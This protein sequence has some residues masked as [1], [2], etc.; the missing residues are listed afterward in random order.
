M[1][2][3]QLVRIKAARAGEV[4]AAFGVD[5][6][7]LRRWSR[8]ADGQGVAALVPA[9]R[10][11]QGPTKLTGQ[12]VANIQ[13]RRAQRASLRAIAAAEGVSTASVRCVLAMDTDSVTETDSGTEAGMGEMGEQPKDEALEVAEAEPEVL[14]QPAPHGT[15]RALAP[16]GLLDEATPVSTPAARV[17]LAGMLAALPALEATGLL[18][19]APGCL[20]SVAGR[21]LR[22]GHDAFRRCPPRLAGQPRAEG[23]G[24]FSPHDLGRVLGMDRAPEAGTIRRK[25]AQ[26]AVQGKA[27]DLLAGMAATH[28][29][30]TDE[31]DDQAGLVLYVDGHVRAYQGTQPVAKTRVSR[32]RFPAPATVDRTAPVPCGSARTHP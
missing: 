10:G 28:L 27:G 32:L 14:A 15:E 9:K 20:R 5:P 8:A 1:A 4:A 2:A 3:V 17:P 31:D 23:A 26:L 19:C 13:N 29:V 22:A 21:V 7:T 30:R 25:I 16:W 11:P 6:E 12:V 24:R 18:A